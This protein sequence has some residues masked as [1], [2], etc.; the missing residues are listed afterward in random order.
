MIRT[1]IFA[2]QGHSLGGGYC[3]LTYGE[4]LRRAADA[5]ASFLQYNFGDMYSLAAPRTCYEPFAAQVNAHTP[6]GGGKYLFRI[7]NHEDPVP[8]VPPPPWP[9]V[10]NVADYPYI[11]VGGAWQLAEG[12]PSKMADEPPPV[13]PQSIPDIIWNAK[14]HRASSGSHFTAPIR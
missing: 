10:S 7:V 11:H 2:R 12:G 8:T 9:L 14:H 4:F 1:E 6:A 13:V 3:A 5:D